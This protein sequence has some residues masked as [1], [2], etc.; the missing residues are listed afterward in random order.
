[1]SATTQA[2]IG[3]I[4]LGHM[5]GNMASRFLAAGFDVHGED[6]SQEGA[7]DLESQGL[8]WE[9]THPTWGRRGS[10]RGVHVPATVAGDSAGA[11]A[12]RGI[13]SGRDLGWC[14]HESRPC[15]R[16]RARGRTILAVSGAW[17]V[18]SLNALSFGAV[19]AVLLAWRRDEEDTGGP[20]ER[21]VGAVRAGL[22]YASF[23]RVL[24]IVLVRAGTFAVASAGLMALMP[25]YAT[26]V[27]HLGSGG[28]G[29]LLGGFGV[30]AVIAAGLLPKMRE[31][32]SEDAVVTIGTLGVAAALLGL[33]VA[34]SVPLALAIVV[35]PARRGSFVSR[36]SMWPL[37]RLSPD[38]FVPVGSRC[39]SPCS[40]G[41][42]R[43]ERRLGIPRELDRDPGDLRV[44][45][46]GRCAHHIVGAQVAA[47]CDRRGR[48][49][50][51][52]HAR[53]GERL[54]PEEASGPACVMITYEVRPGSERR[55]SWLC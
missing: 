28:L 32:V 29:F 50:P 22:R 4:G 6:R 43:R 27:L 12:T 48:P 17:L 31:R 15:P 9:D 53:A 1:M 37:R 25:V 16:P 45:S 14:E 26:D 52:I 39:T 51:F 23:S 38:G 34:R 20:P 42:R 47:A 41:H 5:G 8:Q 13:P 2:R 44:G 11:R 3:F 54:V 49:E 21:F 7:R 30:G 10:R 46:A 40:W 19:V 18:F 35:V 55:S 24:R 36:R 33:A